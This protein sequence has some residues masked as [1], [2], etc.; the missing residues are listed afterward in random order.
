MVMITPV[1]GALEN[2]PKDFLRYI[3]GETPKDYSKYTKVYKN[4]FVFGVGHNQKDIDD[5]FK[6]G[7]KWII[8]V[9]Y[10]YSWN[11]IPGPGNDILIE[12]LVQKFGTDWV[13]TA[14]IEK[15]SVNLASK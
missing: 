15:F 3:N 4:V 12:Y 9:G 10:L 6:V 2:K 14:K 1:I 11:D 8:P 7:N 13:K 5:T